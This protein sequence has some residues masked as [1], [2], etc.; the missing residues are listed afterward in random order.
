MDGIQWLQQLRSWSEVPVIVISARGKEQDKVRALDSGANDYVTKPFSAAELLARIRV[1]R[2]AV[3][4]EDTVTLVEAVTIYHM[5]IEGMLALT[6]GFVSIMGL[7]LAA[8]AQLNLSALDCAVHTSPFL[9]ETQR[10]DTMRLRL[11]STTAVHPASLAP[12][13]SPRPTAWPTRTA[14]A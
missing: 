13:W 10:A 6:G 1:D 2:L 9:T 3:E 8:Q 11:Q 7:F 5:V 14:A 12:R 4:P